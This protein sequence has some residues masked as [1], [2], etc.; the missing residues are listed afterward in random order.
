LR[1]AAVSTIPF[2]ACLLSSS[3]SS[4][5]TIAVAMPFLPP[6]STSHASISAPYSI[7][8][9]LTRRASALKVIMV[10]PSQIH[11]VLLLCCREVF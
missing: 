6:E 3:P 11:H 9:S 7:T 2:R 1:L 4:C 8:P 5:S 10:P